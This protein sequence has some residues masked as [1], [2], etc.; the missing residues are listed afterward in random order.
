MQLLESEDEQL[1]NNI[2]SSPIL[3]SSIRQLAESPPASRQGRRDPNDPHAGSDDDFE[4]DGMLDQDG[5]GE[6]SSLARRIIDL[7]DMGGRQ[8]EESH[9][10]SRA[11][12]PGGAGAGAGA[13]VG[14]ASGAGAGAGA[15]VGPSAG[16]QG[17]GEAPVGSQSSDHAALRAS[18]HRALSGGH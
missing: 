7:T 14:A 5:E 9:F 1:V 18:V 10:G 2:R 17:E 4:D 15:G 13:G 16:Q 11:A 3:M 12:G 8:G 6:I